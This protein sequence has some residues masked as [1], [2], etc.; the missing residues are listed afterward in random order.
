MD[1]HAPDGRQEIETDRDE[2][3][4]VLV[5]DDN[6]RFRSGMVRALGR[7]PDM[8]VVGD[9]VNGALALEAI[10]ELRPRMVLADA[11]MPLVD[12]LEVARGVTADP[13]L[14]ETRVV[15]LSARHDRC[16]SEDARAAG[17][18][19]C[20]DKNDSRREICEAVLSIARRTGPA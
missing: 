4:T 10:R 20:L 7:F 19:D 16:L 6:D 14:S 12:G 8:V 17:A 13:S 11:R 3:V 9:V 15:L 5:A 1:G 18:V 2:R